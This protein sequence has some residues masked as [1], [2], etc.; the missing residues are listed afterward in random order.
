MIRPLLRHAAILALAG[1][2]AACS[3]EQLAVT[4][5]NSGDTKRVLGTPL[6]AENRGCR[7]RRDLQPDDG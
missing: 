2:L 7:L 4:N 3:D 6:D 5:P 1:G